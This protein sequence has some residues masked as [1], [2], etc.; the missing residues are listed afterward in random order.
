MC[1][2]RGCANQFQVSDAE[3]KFAKIPKFHY[4]RAG[5]HQFPTFDAEP[6]I[7]LWKGGGGVSYGQFPKSTSNFQNLS[8]NPKCSISEWGVEGLVKTNFQTPNLKLQS[9]HKCSISRGTRGGGE[10]VVVGDSKFNF[11]T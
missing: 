3:P 1:G 2:G 11:K 8:P 9:K 5:D 7:P 10:G 6:K 4:G